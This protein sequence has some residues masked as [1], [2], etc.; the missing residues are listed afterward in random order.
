MKLRFIF[1]SV[2]MCWT[3]SLFAQARLVIVNSYINIEN[4]AKVVV[5]NGAFNG[6]TNIGTGGIITESEFDQLIWLIGTNSGTYKVPFVSQTT[7]NQ[8]PLTML[9]TTA[10][11]GS[12]RFLL[13]TYPGSTWDNNTY[14]PSTVTHM[15]GMTG[16]ANN[17]AYV[18]D[19]FWIID[20]QS[21]ATK[22]TVT[23]D[24]TYR[25]IEHLQAGNLIAESNLSAQ[26]FNT[27]TNQWGDY[28][29]QGVT[30]TVTNITSSVPVNPADFFRSWTLIDNT[31]PLAADVVSFQA[32]CQS[33]VM[34]FE[35]EAMTELHSDYY[36][37]EYKRAND[38]EIVCQVDA[39]NENESFYQV[40]NPNQRNGVYRLC[41]VNSN[42][43]KTV[44]GFLTMD[45]ASTKEYAQYV[46]GGLLVQ[47]DSDSE[48]IQP[49]QV[50][51]ASGKLVYRTQLNLSHGLNSV[52]LSDILLSQ[53]YYFI[54]MDKNP[55]NQPLKFIIN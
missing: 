53:G 38:Y 7:F 22:P 19:R 25:D 1:L 24:F 36:T 43:V 49:M 11:L 44:K 37:V 18:I 54:Q 3:S 21:Y 23:F 55:E 28:L 13:S 29:P 33:N 46:N 39:K 51:D 6:V 17:S 5:E 4:Q 42:G 50:F 15:G 10:G 30:N 26:R 9:I 52:F 35:W 47:V 41:E 45:C 32:F 34:L 40:S 8:I 20:G 2:F 48:Q 31:Q 14:R 16:T 27:T 12:G